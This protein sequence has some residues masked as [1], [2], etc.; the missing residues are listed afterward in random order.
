MVEVKLCIIKLD[1][2]SE[3]RRISI[4]VLTAST[5]VLSILREK[6]TQFFSEIMSPTNEVHLEFQYEDDIRGLVLVTTSD[7]I[8][9]AA[10]DQASR[11]QLL[12]VFVKFMKEDCAPMKLLPPK[13]VGVICDGCNRSPII[14]VRYKCL[15]CFDYDLCESCADRQ[16]IHAH[17]VLA[18]IRTPHQIDVVRKLCSSTRSN[19]NIKQKTNVVPELV[20]NQPTD[21]EKQKYY[22]STETQTIFFE[23]QQKDKEENIAD[24]MEIIPNN[25]LHDDF[26]QLDFNECNEEQNKIIE[27]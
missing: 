21:I 22:N 17:H 20:V 1:G 19:L 14:G 11:Q 27:Q 10:R 18:K 13:H 2:T 5:D 24:D 12:R 6:L 4:P 23:E 16:L 3:Y 15:E 26:I 8:N 25:I 9:E 7:G